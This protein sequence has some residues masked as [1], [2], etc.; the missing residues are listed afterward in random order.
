[1]LAGHQAARWLPPDAT[2][3]P[4]RKLMP[5]QR[6]LTKQPMVAVLAFLAEKEPPRPCSG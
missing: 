4:T 3:E 1:M 5:Q 6:A 2:T